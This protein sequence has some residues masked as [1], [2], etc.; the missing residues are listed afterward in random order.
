[1]GTTFEIDIPALI[2]GTAVIAQLTDS[3][4]ILGPGPVLL[5]EDNAAVRMV[6]ASILERAGSRVL[7]APTPAAT[8]KLAIS[9]DDP[10]DL[11][12]SDLIM[13]VMDGRE[14]AERLQPMRPTIRTLFSPNWSAAIIKYPF[15]PAALCQIVSEVLG[16]IDS[17]RS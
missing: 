16:K 6:T 15:L 9:H 17:N 2:D 11:L 7:T 1:V 5:A 14:L 10:I 4:I 12:L 13:P 8:L 3:A